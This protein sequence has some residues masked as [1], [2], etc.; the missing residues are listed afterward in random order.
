MHFLDPDHLLTIGFEGDDQGSFGWFEGLALQIFDVSDMTLPTLLH[1]EVIGD[2]GSMSDAT[3]DHLAFNYFS[4]RGLLA[5]PMAICEG[6]TGDGSYGDTMT[7]NGLMVY[8]VSAESGFTLVG[9]V[10]HSDGSTDSSCDNWWTNP[11]SQVK[12]SIFMEDWVFSFSNTRMKVSH[13]DNIESP[14]HSFELPESHWYGA[15]SCVPW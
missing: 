7:F 3:S 8:S 2:R 14:V 6:S 4:S 15:P 5:V 1:K 12:R 13:L 11:D 9:Q 10:D